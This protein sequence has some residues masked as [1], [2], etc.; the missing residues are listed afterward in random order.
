MPL[1]FLLICGE[2]VQHSRTYRQNDNAWYFRLEYGVI[3]H[4]DTLEKRSIRKEI[5]SQFLKI[6]LLKNILYYF[7]SSFIFKLRINLSSSCISCP[8]C[9]RE[10]HMN[11][12]HV[13]SALT[14]LFSKDFSFVSIGI[15]LLETI[16]FF[17]LNSEEP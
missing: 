8:L 5:K 7:S 6:N 2:F 17:S 13:I 3:F 16:V 9:G 12:M 1:S 14:P 11:T 10:L 4:E 15:Y